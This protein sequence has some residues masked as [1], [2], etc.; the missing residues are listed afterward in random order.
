MKIYFPILLLAVIALQVACNGTQKSQDIRSH[1]LV[2]RDAKTDSVPFPTELVHF[3]AI[4]ENPIFTGTEEDT[5][6][7]RMRERGYILKEEDMYH[8]WYT[9]L[10]PKSKSIFLGYATSADG[11]T[12][13]RHPDNPIFD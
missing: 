12:W 2:N 11:L 13:T 1:N 7:Q 4:S 5:W 9:G 8:M 10:R 3:Q 6:D